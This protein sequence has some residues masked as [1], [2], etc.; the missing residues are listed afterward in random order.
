MNMEFVGPNS[1]SRLTWTRLMACS[2]GFSL[3]TQ[4]RGK[5]PCL[6]CDLARRRSASTR[7]PAYRRGR[8][9]LEW[10]GF[11]VHMDDEAWPPADAH[12]PPPGLSTIEIAVERAALR[13][14]APQTCA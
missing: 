1:I 3:Q 14:F 11:E 10:S 4:E 13:F 12:T 9:D 6:A 7:S 8:I 5:A 2:R